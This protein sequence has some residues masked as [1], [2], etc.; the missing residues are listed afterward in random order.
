MSLWVWFPLKRYSF[1]NNYNQVIH[2]PSGGAS[3]CSEE[4]WSYQWKGRRQHQLPQLSFLAFSKL[5]LLQHYY[6]NCH[7]QHENLRFPGD[8]LWWLPYGWRV[9][10]H[11]HLH[12]DITNMADNWLWC[13]WVK[14]EMVIFI[15][16]ILPS[17]IHNAIWIPHG[18]ITPMPWLIL[19]FD[20][21]VW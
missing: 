19:D 2:R 12:G 11:V 16:V 1:Y 20:A 9:R 21:H 6:Q 17:D 3:Q 14:L 5:S 10:A 13:N 4:L 18:N 8:I 15:L 7:Y